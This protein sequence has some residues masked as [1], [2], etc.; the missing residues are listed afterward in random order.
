MVYL[1]VKHSF[2]NN[3]NMGAWKLPNWNKPADNDEAGGLAVSLRVESS[4]A[5]AAHSPA[6]RIGLNLLD[7][8]VR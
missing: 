4:P 6:H 1:V 7:D 3:L 2:D 8:V 5:S